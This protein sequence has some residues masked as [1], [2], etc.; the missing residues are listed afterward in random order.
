M[1]LLRALGKSMMQRT[2]KNKSR[3]LYF[4]DRITEA[5]NGILD[6]P[7]TIVE[8]PMGYGKTTAVMEH[9]I[10][11][12]AHMLWQRVYDS[13]VTGFW[14]GLCRLFSEFDVDRSRNLEQLRFPD[15]SVS[16]REALRLIEYIEIPKKTVLVIDDYHLVAGANVNRFME[17]LLVSEIANLHIILIARYIEL[18]GTEELSLKGYIYHI[19]KDIFELMPKEIKTYYKLCGISIKDVEA[20]ELYSYTEGWISALYLLM[21]N[22][23]KESSFIT[24]VNI[25][26][27]VEKAVYEPFSSDIKDFLLTMCI[28]DSFTL[29][30]ATYMWGNENAEKLIAEVISKNA[31]VSYDVR[32]TTYQMHNIL[33]GFLKDVLETKDMKMNLYRRAAH[34]Y[35][36]A[37]DYK[38]AMHYFY[39]CGDFDT[40]LLAMEEEKGKSINVEYSKELLV[41][42][43][44]ECPDEVKAR[45]HFA[46]L[47]FAIRLFS[48][49]E[50]VLF[51][52]ACGEFIRNLQ[53]DESLNRDIRRRLSGEFE[54]LMSFTKYND[55]AKMS[56]HHRKA[57][58]LLSEPSSL[59]YSNGIWT[60]GS[61]SVLY[62]FYR[63][64]GK[65]EEHV[66]SIREDLPRYQYLTNG[67]AIGGEC[68]MEAEWYFN[69]GDFENAE[70]MVHKA[71]YKAQAKTQIA[72]I[73]CAM[74]LKIRIAF[75]KGDFPCALELL[76][77]MREEIAGDGEYL[78][79][80]TIDMCEGYTY[81]LLE[82]SNKIPEWI[83]LGNFRSSRLLF[84]VHA[85]LNIVYGRVLLSNNEYLKLIGSSE[86]FIDTASFFSNRLANVYTTIYMAAAN[87]RINRRDEAVKAL[88]QALDMAVPDKVYMPF[89]ENCHYIKPLLEKLGTEGIHREAVIRVLELNS[90][91]HISVQ[92]IINEHFTGEKPRLTVREKEIA[93]LAVDGLTNKEIGEKLY[94]SPN[95]VKTQLK[96]IFEKLGV[97]S[98]ALLRQYLEIK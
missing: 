84:P 15:D 20:E 63:E 3:S 74:F 6:Y 11:A 59:F 60:F 67:N 94:I 9:L 87:E 28:C 16:M 53:M 10:T 29:D 91:Y 19:T 82:Q 83:A 46:L 13:S 7:L 48:L 5:M 72:S 41:K 58:D 1:K 54:L 61:P 79:I 22:Y 78:L 88:K 38:L 30:Q 14:N 12:D 86:H 96:S 40:L 23:K 49:N 27:L 52:Q 80:H 45:H 21:L 42:Y 4:P 18:S 68:I 65:L 62:M 39:L 17:F 66:N 97:N 43:F 36:K 70:I 77:G 37:G 35:L 47:I 25:Y 26:K 56:Q 92:K 55:I 81:A 34:W 69:M 33:T 95:T 44:T 71:L 57:W 50:T 2:N 90:A 93:R 8:A 73:I 75:I 85:M 24:T 98:R 31:F 32:T 51:G 89:V 64:T 76:C